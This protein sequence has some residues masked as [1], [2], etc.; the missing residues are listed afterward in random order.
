MTSIHFGGSN[1][2][3]SVVGLGLYGNG[4]AGTDYIDALRFE[5]GETTLFDD[6]SVTMPSWTPA[7]APNAVSSTPTR[8]SVRARSMSCPPPPR[9]SPPATA[10]PPPSPRPRTSPGTGAKSAAPT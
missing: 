2:D 4:A 3:Y 6:P 10:S 1:D 8:S 5:P 9:P 7:T